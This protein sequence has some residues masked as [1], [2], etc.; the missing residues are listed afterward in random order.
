LKRTPDAQIGHRF[1]PVDGAQPP[2][3]LSLNIKSHT[4]GGDARSQAV[5]QRGAY[6]GPAQV[7]VGKEHYLRGE[8]LHGGLHDR[9]RHLRLH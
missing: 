8:V 3:I 4:V 6:V 9:Q 7:V 5:R 1:P 2:D